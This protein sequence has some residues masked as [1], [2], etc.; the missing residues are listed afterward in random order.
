MENVV[1]LD[2]VPCK[3]DGNPAASVQWTHEGKVIN[4]SEPLSRTRSGTYVAKA[5]NPM[6]SSTVTFNIAV[7]RE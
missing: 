2:M 6:G 3:P 4:A 5:E 7:E 1:N